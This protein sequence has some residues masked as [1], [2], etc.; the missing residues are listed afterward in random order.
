MVIRAWAVWRKKQVVGRDDDPFF[1]APYLAGDYTYGV[2]EL[3][4]PPDGV[5][6]FNI[7]VIPYSSNSLSEYEGRH[8]EILVVP[9]TSSLCKDSTLIDLG[10]LTSAETKYLYNIAYEKH[11]FIRPPIDVYKTEGIIDQLA[12]IVNAIEHPS[13]YLQFGEF[14]PIKIAKIPHRR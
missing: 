12:D 8:G 9:I 3:V 1:K 13:W 7:S 14:E 10:F 2:I 5:I 6:G 4:T 11:R